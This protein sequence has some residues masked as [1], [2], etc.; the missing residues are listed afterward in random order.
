VIRSQSETRYDVNVDDDDVYDDC[1]DVDDNKN[2]HDVD[3]DEDDDNNA[4]ADDYF[5]R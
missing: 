1:H 5:L 3:D 2:D 4:N